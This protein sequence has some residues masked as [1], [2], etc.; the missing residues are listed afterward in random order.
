MHDAACCTPTSSSKAASSGDPDDPAHGSRACACD[1]A[2]RCRLLA[3]WIGALEQALVRWDITTSARIAMFL[4]QAAH[5]S[6]ELRHVE[7]NL[8]YSA[9]G[10]VRTWTEYMSTDAGAPVL[11][12]NAG[13]MNTVLR[14]ILV[15]GYGAKPAAGWT[16]AVRVTPPATSPASRREAGN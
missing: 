1:A 11:D 2:C 3:F 6:S 10:L 15:N 5:E 12:G 13:S 14:A 4:A 8:N 7:E 9:E 16:G